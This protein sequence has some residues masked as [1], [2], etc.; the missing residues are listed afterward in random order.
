[1][2][3]ANNMLKKKKKK[4]DDLLEDGMKK[5]NDNADKSKWYYL[6]VQ[7]ASNSHL[8]EYKEGRVIP[9]KQFEYEKWITMLPNPNWEKLEK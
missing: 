1:M 7:E 3:L 9:G 4:I 6:A 2:T 8:Y 5:W